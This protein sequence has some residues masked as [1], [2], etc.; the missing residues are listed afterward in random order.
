MEYRQPYMGEEPYIFISY[1]AKDA[2]YVRP[3]IDTMQQ[4]GYRVWY[5]EGITPGTQWDER[6]AVR[7]SSCNCVL[8][9][10]SQAYF[11]SENCV[12]ELKYSRDLE[13]PLILMSLEDVSLM[14]GMA[15]R[16]GR[17]PKLNYDPNESIEA[18]VA[19]L[20]Q[21]DILDSCHVSSSGVQ[22]DKKKNIISFR[23]RAGIAAV[24]GLV[25]AGLAA[26]IF[27]LGTVEGQST[28]PTPTAV[29]YPVVQVLDND[30]L[31]ATVVDIEKDDLY[32]TMQVKIQNKSSDKLFYSMENTYLDGALCDFTLWGELS[33]EETEVIPFRWERSELEQYE[34]LDWREDVTVIEGDLLYSLQ[35]ETFQ[36]AMIVY[37]PLG[38]DCVDRLDIVNDIDNVY[39]VTG[40]G[41]IA[42]G[43]EV[44]SVRAGENWLG[45]DGELNLVLFLQNKSDYDQTVTVNMEWINGYPGFYKNKEFSVEAG[46]VRRVVLTSSYGN[47]IDEEEQ[48]VYSGVLEVNS[49]D[50]NTYESEC[51]SLFYS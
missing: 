39:D 6:I 42:A 47:L 20:A 51:F 16:V 43:M 22:E 32:Y 18:L 15:L 13:K 28:A 26:V 14:G 19:K 17:H 27:R 34:L 46:R 36:S 25:L 44:L 10:L 45:E 7:V 41:D 50:G 11:D 4:A 5:D 30:L 35:P 23:K 49:E 48:I 38:E 33:G 12:D 9:M 21:I 8:A 24:F 31:T 2:A 3:V 29:V 37:Y 40:M 1:A